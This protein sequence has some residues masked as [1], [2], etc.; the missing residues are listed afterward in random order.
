MDGADGSSCGITCTTFICTYAVF[1]P[2]SEKIDWKIAAQFVDKG[3]IVSVTVTNDGSANLVFNLGVKCSDTV[4]TSP[5]KVP[6]G[7][8]ITRTFRAL[9]ED[10]VDSVPYINIGNAGRIRKMRV[11]SS[12]GVHELSAITAGTWVSVSIRGM[13][14]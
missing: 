3:N 4:I 2:H 7:Q 11:S 9:S 12:R 13:Y 10:N 8:T 1:V 5:V 14:L 6:V